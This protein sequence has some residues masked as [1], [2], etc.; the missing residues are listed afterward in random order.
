LMLERTSGKKFMRL[1]SKDLN[2]PIY[3]QNIIYEIMV[4]LYLI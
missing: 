3:S 1:I 2:T 4:Q